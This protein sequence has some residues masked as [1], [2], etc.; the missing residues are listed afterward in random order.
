MCHRLLHTR[1]V[2]KYYYWSTS[3]L[4]MRPRRSTSAQQEIGYIMCCE[5]PISRCIRTNKLV[6]DHLAPRVP[7]AQSVKCISLTP[8][9]QRVPH[10]KWLAKRHTT[11]VELTGLRHTLSYVASS[12]VN[13]CVV[14]ARSPYHRSKHARRLFRDDPPECDGLIQLFQQFPRFP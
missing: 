7:L 8:H 6:R 2:T 14:S 3:L 5:R 1:I 9:C 4:Q 12:V 13:L 11:L 10:T